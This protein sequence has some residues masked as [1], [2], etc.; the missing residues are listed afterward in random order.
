[1]NHQEKKTSPHPPPPTNPWNP[2]SPCMLEP[3]TLLP[4]SSLAKPQVLLFETASYEYNTAV[5]TAQM[6]PHTYLP[7]DQTFPEHLLTCG[8]SQDSYLNTAFDRSRVYDYPNL[9][10]T[11]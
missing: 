5:P 11:L 1:F 9:Q 10:H 3:G 2:M 7:L 4:S 8:S 6:L